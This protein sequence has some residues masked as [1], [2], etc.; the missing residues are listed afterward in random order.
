MS[1]I[2]S[3]LGF[4]VITSIRSR[5]IYTIFDRC[6]CKPSFCGIELKEFE[7]KIFLECVEDIFVMRGLV[8]EGKPHL[9]H[10]EWQQA[11]S[12][13]TLDACD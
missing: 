9:N 5:D 7:E 1:S 11:C 8:F 4:F 12:V 13:Q 6:H 10:R 2:Y 3:I